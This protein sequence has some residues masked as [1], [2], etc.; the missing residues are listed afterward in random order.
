[1]RATIYPVQKP[2]DRIVVAGPTERLSYADAQKLKH[3]RPA[4]QGDQ[5]RPLW[6][7]FWFRAKAT[8]PKDWKGRRVDLH[9][10][11]HS[12]ATLWVNG[13]TV[14]GLNYDPNLH[15][16]AERPDAVLI[17]QAS[18]GETVE[19]Q[20]EAAC[21]SPFGDPGRRGPYSTEA[22]SPF[23]FDACEL[24]AFDPL[25]WQIYYDLSVLVDLE[26]EHARNL[27]PT[28]AGELLFELNRFANVYDQGD[29]NT[30]HAAHEIIKP[31]YERHN[32]RRV[33]EV[34]AIGHAHIDTAWLWPLAE[35]W[36]KC[37]RT[38]SSQTAYMDVYPDYKFACSQAY[39]YDIV[40]QRNPDLYKRIKERVKRG[41]WVPV[42]GTWI[43]PDCNI[44][45]GEALVRQFL[46][47]Q[48]FFQREF[49]KRCNE[50]WNPDVFGY[51]G[52]LPQ[53]MRGA[54]IKRFLTQK[55]SW[56]KFTKPPHHTFTWQGIDGSEVIAHFP[57]ADTYNAN[58]SVQEI[59]H[60]VANYK[61]HDRSR[62]SYYL[63]GFGDGGGG[64]TKH[65]IEYL[66]RMEDL[67]GL[68]RVAVRSSDDFFTRLEKDCSHLPT[69]VGEL[70]LEIHRGTLTTQA[71][72]KRNNRRSE[73]LLHDAEFL[74]TVK[75]VT[76]RSE[77]VKPLG[78][79]GWAYA[80]EAINALWE[81]V[82]LNQFHDILPGSSIPQV[83]E[84]AAR[85]YEQVERAGRGVR[86]HA[87][88]DLMHFAAHA[89]ATNANPRRVVPVNT[90]GV[91]RDELATTPD[92]KLCRVVAPSM[93]F[94]EVL[95]PSDRVTLKATDGG[96][97]LQN[98]HL[99]ATVNR[100]GRITS[101][102]HRG[103]GREALAGEG[104]LFQIFDDRP[105]MWDAWDVDPY[106]LETMRDCGPASSA[107]VAC[108]SA[109]RAE[110]RFEHTIGRASTLVQTIRLDAHARR[111]EVHCDV[112]WQEDHKFLKVAF[113]VNA[114]A[115]NA[116]FEMQFGAVERPTHFNTPGDLAKY[117]VA[118]HR[119][120]DLSEHGFGVS[121]L[122]ESKYGG[123][124]FGNCMRLS[125]L[126]S[127]KHPDP[128]A[129]RGRQRFAYALFPHAGDWRTGG[130][131]AE[132][133]RFNAPILFAPGR[134]P[135]GAF[136]EVDSPDLVIDTVKKAEDSDHVIV[137]LYECHGGRGKA[138]LR[139]GW[140]AKSASRAN[141]LEDS[142]TNVP[143]S[144]GGIGLDYHPYE[145][146][147]LKIR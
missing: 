23:V 72:T 140:R 132:G 135:V 145:I 120:M 142:G 106:H 46:F 144:A 49:G 34:S 20:V 91:A 43:E 130:T 7:T 64:P 124:V 122:S 48:R 131:V 102:V 74:Q 79:S 117:E 105:V 95:E 56:N 19:F 27:D 40:R 109:M 71:A 76:A 53:I 107:G 9:W 3:F 55:L 101:L 90:I 86:E 4:R 128:L 52:Q 70:Y 66:S 99:T 127:P 37:D 78:D 137:R 2:V 30:W 29:R 12:E 28:W 38:F 11:S 39:Q 118:L 62:H 92:G 125:L 103:T 57:P 80:H 73:W 10:V 22:V 141:L 5:L 97:V 119:W 42:G 25:A 44:P 126:R 112:D 123:S 65:M 108:E 58:C 110:V 111:V 50:F 67:Q 147:T 18:G 77:K 17:P 83:Y 89:K 113:P 14:Q 93:G 8:V 94:G 133:L 85:Q 87:L 45:S 36:R 59:R 68:P 88:R 98:T 6:A 134:V 75:W 35:T 143:V 129:D 69:I 100:A 104:N 136:V 82:L 15:D 21:N 115:M 24:R 31:L 1:M 51:N 47:G 26:A 54:G 139:L 138:Q 13:K 114:R 61:D 33:H 32:G 60:S 84:D 96:W 81:I 41:Q 16:R 146:I 121:I 116:T 63:F